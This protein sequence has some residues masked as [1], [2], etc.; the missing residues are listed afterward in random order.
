[1]AQVPYS[2]VPDVQAEGLPNANIRVQSSPSAFGS[3]IGEAEQKLGADTSQAADQTFNVV[4]QHQGMLNETM[5]TNAETQAMSQYGD[6][7]NKYKSTEGLAAVANRPQAIEDIQAVRQKILATLPNSAVQRAFNMLALRHESNALEDTNNYATTQVKAADNRSA[8]DAMQLAA[9]RVG[10]YS[11]ASNDKRFSDAV[12]DADFQVVRV[13]NNQGYG[14]GSGSGMK[15]DAK[16]GALT[17]DTSTPAGQQAKAVYDN[18]IAKVHGDMWETRI[19][20]IADDPVNGNTNQAFAVFSANRDKIPGET[21]AKIGAFLLPRVRSE[22]ASDTANTALS[23]AESGYQGSFNTAGGNFS[24]S[25]AASTINKLFPGSVITSALRTPGHNAAVGGVPDSMHVTGQAVDFVPPKGMTLQDVQSALDKAGIPHTELIRDPNEADHI[26]WGWGAKAS[27]QPQVPPYQS[28]ADYYRANSDTI[29][30]SVRDQAT[31]QHPDDP[32]FADMAVARTQ[33][34]MSEVITHQEQQYSVDL[35]T[36][37]QAMNGGMTNG[38]IPTSVDAMAS[39]NPDVRKAWE[40]VQ[41]NNPYAASHIENVFDANSRGKALNYGADFYKYFRAVLAPQN[42]PSRVADPTKLWPYVQPG[43]DG[44]ITNTG[45]AALTRLITT[46]N[47]PQGEADVE[48]MRAF[49]DQAHRQISGANPASGIADPKGEE[50]FNKFMMLAIPEIAATQQAKKPLSVLFNPKS[51]DYL[52]NAIAN[53]KRP[54]AQE[55]NDMIQDYP[56]GNAVTVVNP[57]NLKTPEDLIAAVQSG[58]MSRADGEALALKRG[59]IRANPSP[60]P[61]IPAPTP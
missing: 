38:Q 8:S 32:T 31:A 36:V 37:Q 24:E 60:E 23:H 19:H 49:F 50:K 53:F 13:L 34:K 10:D 59:Y 7:L 25:D 46:R 3:N 47:S 9:S 14:A 35:H 18:M 54:Y 45:L 21:Q 42:D 41:A 17:F 55:V 26:H 51:P 2:G 1:M 20:A 4:M 58:K 33:Q 30:Q 28:R 15:Q 5:A 27:G 11:V 16:T 57:D 44:P 40:S 6:I 12:Q 61:V 52:G 22:Q 29:L 48:Q 39:I 43:E 56:G